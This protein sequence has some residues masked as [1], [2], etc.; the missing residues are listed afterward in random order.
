MLCF[1]FCFDLDKDFAQSSKE[2]QSSVGWASACGRAKHESNKQFVLTVKAEI[3][4]L[5]RKLPGTF[6]IIEYTY[7][8][9]MK[10][11]KATY[12]STGK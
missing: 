11:K 12:S 5:G 7:L 4:R 2:A 1:A 9:I 10:A 3:K 6:G 8:H